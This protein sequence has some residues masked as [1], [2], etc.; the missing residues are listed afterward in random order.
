MMINV[1]R[2]IRVINRKLVFSLPKRNKERQAPV[3]PGVLEQLDDHLEMFTAV[4]V[5]LPWDQPNGQLVTVNLLITKE[6]GR[7]Y[8]G[9]LFNKVV[10]T[11]AFKRAGLVY[12]NRQD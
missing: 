4:P 2:Q 9:D 8:G 10:W 6:D 11:P 5:T 3:S 12:T 1:C 7:P